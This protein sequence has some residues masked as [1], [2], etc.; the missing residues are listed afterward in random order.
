MIH[1]FKNDNP[2]LSQTIM[3]TNDLNQ[4]GIVFFKRGR[5]NE[6]LEKIIQLT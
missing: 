6:F 3:V 4:E 5:G 1:S 2:K